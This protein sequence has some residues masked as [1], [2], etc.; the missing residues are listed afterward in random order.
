MSLQVA[1][2]LT[3]VPIPDVKEPFHGIT[4][5]VF[6]YRRTDHTEEIDQKDILTHTYRAE[7]N[8]DSAT[9]INRQERAVHKPPVDP[10]PGSK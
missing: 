9:A 6:Q 5:E 1:F 8:H 3:V 4:C 7:E 2:V 10:F